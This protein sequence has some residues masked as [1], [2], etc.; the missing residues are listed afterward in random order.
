MQGIAGGSR[1]GGIVIDCNSDDFERDVAFWAE[2]LGLEARQEGEDPRY[3]DLIGD[4]G[5]IDVLVQKVEHHPRIHL[6]I[7]ATDRVAEV[8]RLKALGAV[9]VADIRNWTVMEAP[10]GHRFCVV[11]SGEAGS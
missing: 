10:S 11:Q 1:L 9:P 4:G 8:E 5:G 3:V 6:D 2:A 7:A